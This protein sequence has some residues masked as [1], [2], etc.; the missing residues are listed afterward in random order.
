MAATETTTIPA[1]Q[2]L[3][4]RAPSPALVLGAI[5]SV[6]FGAAIAA[7][8]FSKIGP[9]GAVWLRL[10]FG[11]A[12]LLALWRPH[13]R[14]REYTR[15]QLLLACVFGLVLGFMNLS[16][17]SAIHRIPLGIAVTLEF[18]GPLTVAV[19][20]SRRPI[21]LVWVAIAA[22]GII[23]LTQGDTHNLNALGVGLAL[24]AGGL[25][26]TYILVNARVGQAFSGGT[27]LALA[28]CI[29]SVAILPFGIA[30]GG[31]QLLEPRSLALGAAVGLLSSAIPYSFEIEA[32][33]RIKPSVFGVLMSIEPAMAA[34][35]GFIVLG[36]G[37]SART[38]LGMAL[39]VVASVGAARRTREAPVAV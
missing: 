12:I 30:Q 9:G 13:L 15:Y 11:T 5:A 25:W 4:A 29:A 34:L 18:I 10:L 39:V 2:G 32:L 21:D 23:A 8:L 3:L 17:Y 6:Q 38:L 7:T 28:M 31:S 16:F 26:G 35:A 27:G 24:L 14:L 36:Q 19:A 33:R 37:L 1:G 22:G 20:G